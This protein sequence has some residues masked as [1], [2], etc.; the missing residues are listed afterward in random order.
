M[1]DLWMNGNDYRKIGMI[2]YAKI[3]GIEASLKNRMDTERI[4]STSL[5]KDKLNKTV[6]AAAKLEI[7]S[8]LQ[9]TTENFRGRL[10]EHV[11]FIVRSL[12]QDLVEV[13][14]GEILALVSNNAEQTVKDAVRDALAGLLQGNNH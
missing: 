10:E 12:T 5:R 2:K 1:A 13:R 8:E 14:T 3:R 11:N 7:H 4:G 9:E 6:Q